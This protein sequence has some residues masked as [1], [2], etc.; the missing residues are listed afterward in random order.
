MTI[1]TFEVKVNPEII[2]WA[3]DTSGL[4]IKDL[5]KKLRVSEETIQKWITGKKYPTLKQLENLSR[6]VRRPLSI[7]LLPYPP[8]EKPIPKD[9]RMLPGKEGVFHRETIL[10]I[11]KARKLQ[12]IAKELLEDLGISSRPYIMYSSLEEDPRKV[13]MKYR[14]FFKIREDIQRKWK[15]AYEAFKY[16]RKSI[17]EL[18][19]FIFQISMPIEDVRGFTLAD[20]EPFAIIVNSR[21]GMKPRLFTLMHEFGHILLK[22]SIIDIPEVSLIS[23][24]ETKINK[25]E[26]WCNEFA[27]EFL[28][29]SEIAKREFE[30][31]REHLL[32]DKVL[33]MLSNEFKV[34][35]TML[36]YKMMKLGYISRDTYEKMIKEI[37][38]TKKRVPMSPAKKCIVEKG[39]KFISLV[40][41]NLQKGNITFDEALEYLGIK[42]R[43]YNEI[44]SFLE[45]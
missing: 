16:L 33:N 20:E 5:S 31:Y 1:R 14:E 43:Y 18:N 12:K 38:T 29:P 34:S 8:K 27:S 35:K 17:E 11:R 36:L 25:V 3:I 9:Y 42:M 4:S 24:E 37:K 13:A 19:I 45:K 28:L 40:E 15:N 41:L 23:L 32:E 7:F 21:E 30:K 44:I 10:A 2:K 6:Y 39:E 22:E 26:R